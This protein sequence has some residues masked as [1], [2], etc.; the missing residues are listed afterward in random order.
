MIVYSPS[1]NAPLYRVP[2]STGPSRLSRISTQRIAKC[3]IAG[4]RFCRTANTSCIYSLRA[5]P[6]AEAGT[7]GE[8]VVASLDGTVTKQLLPNGYGARYLSGGYIAFMRWPALLAQRFNPQT[9]TLEGQDL[10]TLADEIENAPALEG[11]PF[12]VSSSGDVLVYRR[13][14]SPSGEQRDLQWFGRDGSRLATIGTPDRYWSARLSPDGRSVA[15]EIEAADTR[16]TNVWIY[17]TVKSASPTRFTFSE[18]PD[19]APIWAPDGKSI[20]FSSRGQGPH[21]SLFRKPSD[22]S[23]GEQQ[24][25]QARERHLRGRLVSRRTVPALHDARSVRKGRREYLGVADAGHADAEPAVS[26]H[27]RRSISA[28]LPGRPIGCVSIQRKRTQ[29]DLRDPV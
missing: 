27:R 1:A 4:R 2:S 8:L 14:G 18:S 12:S 28:L 26:Q 10:T 29:S 9:L 21:F 20:V 17:D 23:S 13:R 19:S 5:Q 6:T 16:A 24:L 22:G 25:L 15:V 11:P 7:S 3:R